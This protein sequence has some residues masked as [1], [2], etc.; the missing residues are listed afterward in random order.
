MYDQYD[1]KCYERSTEK[2]QI[3]REYFYYPPQK[4]TLALKDAFHAY[5]VNI[6]AQLK[7]F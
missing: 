4:C 7:R 3:E 2:N 1:T 6:D 5:L